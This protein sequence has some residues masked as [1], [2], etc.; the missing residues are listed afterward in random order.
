[1]MI[2]KKTCKRTVKR[3]KWSEEYKVKVSVK[4]V[5]RKKSG[6]WGKETEKKPKLICR[7]CRKGYIN[8]KTGKCS[9]CGRR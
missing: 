5:K 2:K 8:R 4:P 9:K 1:M 7:Y 6:G 3:G